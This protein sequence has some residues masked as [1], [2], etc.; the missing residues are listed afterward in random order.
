METQYA[1]LGEQ[2]DRER[3]ELLSLRQAVESFLRGGYFSA[4]ASSPSPS[5]LP[6]SLEDSDM[7]E[8]R[9]VLEGRLLSE[10]VAAA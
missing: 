5:E 8:G 3:R 10:L 9:L 4:T 2:L 7:L 6:S 1:T